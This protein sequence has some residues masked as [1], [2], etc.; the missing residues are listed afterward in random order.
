MGRDIIIFALFVDKLKYPVNI[1]E[2][3]KFAHIA[4][5]HLG[6]F[7]KNPRLRDL[8]LKAFEKAIDKSV[9]GRVDFILIAGDL[10]HNPI[11]DM[12]IV[13]RTVEILKRAKDEGIRIYAIY[14]SHDFSA[15]TTSLLDVLH[16]A[17]LFRKAVNY[18]VNGD[19]LRL[20]P[21]KDDTGASIVGISGLSS[22]AEVE[23][24]EHLDREYLENIPNP[25]IFT[26][27]TSIT[28]L[29][30]SYISDRYA[31]PKSLLPKGFDYYAGGHLHERIVSD[32]N[33]APLIY[34]GALFGATYN[35]LDILNERGFFIVEDFRPR[36]VKIEVCKFFK[37]VIKADGLSAKEL[38]EKLME[39]S[40]GDYGESVVILKVKGELVSGR[41]SDIDF[42]T[43]RE[44]FRKTALD[45]LLNTY[46]LGSRERR[47]IEVIGET[48]EDIENEALKKISRYGFST[49]RRVFEILKE[50]KPED[51]VSRDFANRL[52]EQMMEILRELRE[53]EPPPK[54]PGS[55]PA[56]LE[57]K[58]VGRRTLFDFGGG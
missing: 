44:N 56:E 28:E 16:T 4:D 34:P 14:G 37:R 49:T 23:Y 36:F 31:V 30:P 40:R 55:Q 10:F 35:D 12:E 6:A 17:G 57:E 15:G 11:P 48:K 2:A 50:R 51:M 45:V 52:M 18:E 42:H 21:V 26:F 58:R 43:I 19:K 47:K 33:G 7:S 46:A 53:E 38:E 8:N 25:K 9:E 1:G 39:L 41:V 20:I 3:M 13:R 5:A 54:T 32:L 27:H 29:K 24:F 22:A